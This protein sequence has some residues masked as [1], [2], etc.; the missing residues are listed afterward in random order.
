[1]LRSEV[2]PAILGKV[3]QGQPPESYSEIRTVERVNER[4]YSGIDPTQPRKVLHDQHVDLVT[5][6]ER[7]EKVEYKKWQPASYEAAHH[8]A[9]RLSRLR[10][11]PEG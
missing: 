9:E 5:I 4:I 8:D 7:R 3:L 6:Y 11:P 10:F 1:M 2:S